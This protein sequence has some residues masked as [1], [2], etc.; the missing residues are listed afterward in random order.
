VEFWRPQNGQ[1]SGD[2]AKLARAIVTLAGQ[3]APRQAV[4]SSQD[5]DVHAGK[6]GLSPR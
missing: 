4:G 1:Q 3:A 5:N 6:T 2:P